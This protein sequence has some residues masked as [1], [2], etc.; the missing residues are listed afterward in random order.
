M[1]S[2]FVYDLCHEQETISSRLAKDPDDAPGV[3]AKDLFG[4]NRL[5]DS[6]TT[7]QSDFNLQRAFECGNWGAS[8]PS[9]LFLKV[10]R[11]PSSF[12][13]LLMSWTDI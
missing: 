8:R 6:N 11:S 2:D 3:I 12:L 10:R 13:A 9:D 5:P 7:E 1:I 4:K